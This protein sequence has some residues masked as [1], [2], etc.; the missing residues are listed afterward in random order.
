MSFNLPVAKGIET[1]SAGTAAK[2]S[3]LLA[4]SHEPKLLILDEP[5]S[6]LDAIAREEFIDEVVR[7]S[8]SNGQTVIFSSHIVEDIER[9]CDIILILADGNLLAI[10]PLN[11][12]LLDT[13]RIQFRATGSIPEISEASAP[14]VIRQTSRDSHHTWTVSGEV[15]HI[16]RELTDNGN[17]VSNIKISDM[18]LYEI[19]KDYLKGSSPQHP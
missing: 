8:K 3:L 14:K 6:N 4:L 19:F 15:E 5:T 18:S 17:N 7:T 2:L 13:N 16:V 9:I 11:Q 10:K 12:L 1:L